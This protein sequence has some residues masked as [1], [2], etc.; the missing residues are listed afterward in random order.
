MT[1]TS[2]PEAQIQLSNPFQDSFEQFIIMNAMVWQTRAMVEIQ[3]HIEDRDYRKLERAL[4]RNRPGMA[5]SDKVFHDLIEPFAERYV[6]QPNSAKG[7]TLVLCGAGPSLKE[8]ID[9]YAPK[10]D[11]IWGC[12]SAVTWLHKQGYNPT[13][14]LTVDQTA[15]M[16]LEWRDAPEDIEYL[17]ASTIHPH[18]ADMLVN[19]GSRF[20][21]F[22]NYVGMKGQHI[23]WP[24]ANGKDRTMSREEWVYALLFPGTIQA[25]S[26]LN[27]VNRAIDVAQHMGFEKIFVLGA[28]CAM[29]I[30]GKPKKGL[31][32]GSPEQ[33]AYL[34]KQS[35][36]HVD[37][38]HAL[39]SE[40][41]ALILEAEIDGRFWTS[42]FDLCISAVW[43]GRQEKASKGQVELIGD[44]LPNFIKDRPPEWIARLPSLMDSTGSAIKIPF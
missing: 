30:K 33:L 28:D 36:F 6:V 31:A 11:Q 14:G 38:G 3:G 8:H 21:Y 13:H 43:L 44:T 19:R 7:Q 40:A 39:A 22:N 9:E 32:P 1:T 34:K 18:L 37:G 41:T 23:T 27:T 12:N 20:K 4:M 2:K 25:G 5:Y 16:Y 42:K 35:V 26:G 24:D 10:A 29:Q 17:V 15:H